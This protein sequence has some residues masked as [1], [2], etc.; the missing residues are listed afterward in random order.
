MKDLERFE[1]PLLL[2]YQKA[3]I[4]TDVAFDKRGRSRAQHNVNAACSAEAETI[5][6]IARNGSLEEKIALEYQLQ[7]RDLEKYATSAG[8]IKNVEQGLKDLRAGLVAYRDLVERPEEYRKQATGYTDRNR[9][10]KLDVPKDGMRYALASQITRLQN[11]LSLQL[12]EEEKVLLTARRVLLI[13]VQD[14]YS[15]IQVGAVHDSGA[16]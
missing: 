3:A 9:D 4:F 12:S 11:R 2:Q 10:A 15:A 5:M 8:E 16:E 13:A 14:E 1:S 7:R 6:E